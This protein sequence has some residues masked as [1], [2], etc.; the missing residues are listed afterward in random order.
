MPNEQPLDDDVLMGLV[1]L[2]L[3]QPEDQREAYLARAC[4]GNPE[5]FAQARKYVEWESRMGTFL[6]EPFYPDSSDQSPFEPGQLLESRFRIVREVARGGMGIVYEAQDEKLGRRIA[7]KCAKEGF[8][9]R[10]PPEVRNASEISHP[11][12]CKIFEIH[13]NRV[14]NR[15]IDFMTMEFLDGETLR[16]RLRRGPVPPAEA[17]NIAR[18]LAAGLAE[19]HKNGVTH[20][21]LKSNNVI[22]TA[23]PDGTTRAVITDFG[24]AQGPTS[25]ATK[26]GTPDYMAP[27][28]WNGA[29]SSP[30]SDIYA[31]GVILYELAAGRKPFASGIPGPDRLKS[32]PQ[33]V[34]SRWDPILARCLD[35]D[36]TRRFADGSA[37]EEALKPSTRRRWYFAAAAAAALA[38]ITGTVTYERASAPKQSWRLAMLPVQSDDASREIAARLS[39]DASKQLAR[40]RG[41]TVARF[42]FVPPDRPEAVATHILRT[43]LSSD[44]SQF[45]LRAVL[46][47]ARNGVNGAEWTSDY[48]GPEMRYAPVA[49][50]G[51]ITSQL[52]L[53]PLIPSPQINAAAKQDY[54]DGLWYMRLY[55]T[56]DRAL[57]L[58]RRAT[59]GDSDS[60]LAWAALSEAQQWKWFLTKD[61]A[62]MQ[63]AEESLREAR[64]RNPDVEQVHRIAGLLAYRQALYESA[65]SELRRAI[66]LTPNDGEAHRVLGQTYEATNH[67][68]EAL[69]EYRKA[70]EVDG[71]NYRNHQ[72][73]GTYFYNRTDYH[74]ALRHM[75]KAADLE[76]DEPATHFNLGSVYTNL[77]DFPK[78]ESELRFAIHLGETPSYLSS[79]GVVLMEERKYREAAASISRALTLGG[80][81]VLWQMNLG[82]AYRLMRQKAESGQAYLRAKK[83]AEENIAKD[84]HD[85]TTRSYLAF[86]CAQ[87]RDPD[88]AKFEIDQA[89][90]DLPND[91][92][93]RF[94]A[95][96]TWEALG[97]RDDALALLQTFS[98]AELAAVSQWPD[99]ADLSSDSRFL[100]L[101]ASNPTK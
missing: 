95:V 5:L 26:G 44:N 46:S 52:G 100:K 70:V 45:H 14:G 11:A 99:M 61:S 94:M 12:V 28:L 85:A 19:A 88:R 30:A 47:D 4:A 90:R 15:E 27:E 93:V 67:L 32:R 2:A 17:R 51:L 20:G 42:Q 92:R 50:A 53:P 101:T 87:L 84:S 43:S 83:L 76:P 69:A 73:L 33:S 58:L 36:P 91:G 10:L 31:L 86:V 80:E 82:T 57:P 16:D 49:L 39:G 13:T 23:A 66:A 98:H 48:T 21:D 54:W 78:A 59:S 71:K 34:N 65:A 25:V 29:P 72:Q 56:I 8:G 68:D 35:P 81:Q 63:R 62:W 41:G 1:E 75:E 97:R 74:E 22:L 9:K 7:I 79:L 77:G 3:A 18:Q 38:I 37:V 96:A 24:L 60:P 6:L 89:I 64:R 40:L 55:S